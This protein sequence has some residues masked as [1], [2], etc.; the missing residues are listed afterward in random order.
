MS[1]YILSD[2]HTHTLYTLDMGLNDFLFDI[3]IQIL[4]I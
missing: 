3:H 1:Y 4:L 2:N